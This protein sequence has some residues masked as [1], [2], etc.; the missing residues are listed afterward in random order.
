MHKIALALIPIVCVSMS[1]CVSIGN[2]TTKTAA[3]PQEHSRT[4]GEASSKTIPAKAVKVAVAS[5][6]TATAMET[7]KT[8]AGSWEGKAT[9]TG[10]PEM[11]ASTTFAVSSQGTAVREI[12]APGGQY[13]MTNMYHL[14]GN[15]LLATH[16][17]GA[18]NQPRMVATTLGPHKIVFELESI[19][20]FTG[21]DH[22]YMGKLQFE[23]IDKDH[24]VQTWT[25]IGEDGKGQSEGVFDLRRK[26]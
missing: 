11:H 5:A 9:F 19:T 18:G 20:N 15:K 6:E 25:N 24:I 12:M 21:G 26:S 7:L 13:E 2:S 1:A 10:N 3:T 23:F 14:D 4:A 22:G 16:Y 8:L 17:C